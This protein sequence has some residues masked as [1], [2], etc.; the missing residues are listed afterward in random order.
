MSNYEFSKAQL[1]VMSMADLRKLADY[2]GV[3]SATPRRNMVK[4]IL[5]KQLDSIPYTSE[6]PPNEP[7]MS[8]RLR[9]IR[10]SIEGE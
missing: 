9:R 3:D 10:A 8:V 7:T 2:Y 6:T 5:L 4:S 1:E